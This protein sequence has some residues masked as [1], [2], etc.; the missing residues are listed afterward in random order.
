ML[1]SLRCES[2]SRATMRFDRDVRQELWQLCINFLD[3]YKLP[4]D[5]AGGVQWNKQYVIVGR[6]SREETLCTT[7]L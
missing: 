3:W 1:R 6:L 5:I 4:K 2:G 7:I